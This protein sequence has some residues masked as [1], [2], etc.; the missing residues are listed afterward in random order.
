LWAS[1]ET[2][3]HDASANE[4]NAIRDFIARMLGIFGREARPA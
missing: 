4:K 2:I 3:W 1:W